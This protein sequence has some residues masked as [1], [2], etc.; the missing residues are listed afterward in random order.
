MKRRSLYFLF[1]AGCLLLFGNAQ[2]FANELTDI[3]EESVVLGDDSAEENVFSAFDFPMQLSSILEPDEDMAKAQIMYDLIENGILERIGMDKTSY[4]DF[5]QYGFS[6]EDGSADRELL[7]KVYNLVLFNHPECFYATGNYSRIVDQ[8]KKLLGITP[9]YYEFACEP[10]AIEQFNNAVDLR[11]QKVQDMDNPVEIMLTL[12]DDLAVFNSYNWEVDTRRREEAGR[13]AWTAY[14][15]LVSGNPTCS[16][17]AR[18]YRLLLLRRGIP[19]IVVSSSEM[20]HA[21][22]IVKIGDYCYHV[23]VTTA[24]RPK[25]PS[26]RGRSGHQFFLLSDELI[27]QYGYYNWTV[28]GLQ[29]WEI[30]TPVCESKLFEKGWAFSNQADYSYRNQ[31]EFPFYRVDG[32]YYSLRRTNKNICS[33][34]CG[35]ISEPGKKLAELSL[36]TRFKEDGSWWTIGSGI[37]WANGCLYYVDMDKNLKRYELETGS[38]QVIGYIPFEP[39]PSQDGYFTDAVDGIGLSYDR[40]TGKIV[41]TSRTRREVIACFPAS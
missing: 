35:A 38:D 17:Y 18:A 33:L 15:A 26:L 13:E 30:P 20:N 1:L 41:A 7:R 12:Y 40:Q 24:N 2:V 23:D 16:G 27:M 9:Q 36:Y 39:M 6:N 14:G 29:G 4:I 10:G 21:W 25:P 28:S 37:V 11:L 19:C 8:D 32:N 31:A 34:Y 5:K 22:N 3:A